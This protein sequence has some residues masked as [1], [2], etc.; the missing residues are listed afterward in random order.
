MDATREPFKIDVDALDW[1][2][3]AFFDD[4][5]DC[6]LATLVIGGTSMH[7]EA[8]AVN[9]DEDGDIFAAAIAYEA[10]IKSICE[11]VDGQPM[12]T[13]IKGREYVLRAFPYQR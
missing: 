12:V 5:S 8:F 4:P 10:D 11:A 7:L 6:L 1:R 3:V 9:V 13:G 2:E